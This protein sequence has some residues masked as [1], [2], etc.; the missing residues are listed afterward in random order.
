MSEPTAYTPD[1]DME[2]TTVSSLAHT[3]RMVPAGTIGGHEYWVRMEVA[4]DHPGR[5][6]GPMDLHFLH[7]ADEL[8]ADGWHR[9]G[10]DYV[11]TWTWTW[12]SE[13]WSAT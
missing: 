5:T 6:Y 12:T 8:D 11:R 2:S 1:A 3:E 4:A 13:G 7:P 10:A 9:D